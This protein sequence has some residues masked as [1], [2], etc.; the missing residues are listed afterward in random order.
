[1][2][3]PGGTGSFNF[4]LTGPRG[5][6]NYTESYQLVQEG[7]QWFGP[8]VQF[9]IQVVPWNLVYDN[10]SANFSVSGSWSTGT[11][12]TDKY[13]R[14]YRWISTSPSSTAFARWYLNAPID[15][16]YDVYVWWSQGSNRSPQARYEVAHANGTSV[17]TV[18]QQTNGGRW[19]YL[20]RFPPTARWRRCLPAR[21]QRVRLCGDCGRRAYRRTLLNRWGVA[22]PDA[23]PLHLAYWE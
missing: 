9:N 10:T 23:T 6:G 14:D 11:M 4:I 3:A 12:A 2:V 8:I 20:G 5:Y 16:S 1:M 17:V 18:N 22:S 19:V 15:G 7:V 13:G 21:E